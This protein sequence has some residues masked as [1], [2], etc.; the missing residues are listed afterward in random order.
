LKIRSSFFLIFIFSGLFL[1]S[2]DSVNVKK[3]KIGDTNLTFH[4]TIYYPHPLSVTFINLHDDENTSVNAGLDFLSKYGG[5]L[6]QLQHTGKRN[7]TFKINE[8]SFSFDPNRIFT[9]TGLQATLQKQSFYRQDAFTE[10]KKIADSILINNVNDKKLIIALH[11]NT[12]DGLSILSFKRKGY[13]ARNASRLYIN[14]S[15]DPDDFI[16]T[17]DATIF[18]YIK[19][20]KINV[21]L[22]HP[23][24]EDNGSL[25]VYAAKNKI[26]YINVEAKHGYLEQQ[27]KMLEALKDLIYRY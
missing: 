15:M 25:S 27:I 10:V 4:T 18:H 11:N 17:T 5:T 1:Y 2:Q 26:N 14:L 8:D 13:E 6:F 24:P 9:D 16:I 21:V 3:Y 20:R 19:H 23:K 12:E 7:F 22:Q